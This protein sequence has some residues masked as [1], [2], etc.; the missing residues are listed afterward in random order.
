MTGSHTFPLRTLDKYLIFGNLP[1]LYQE[2]PSS[3]PDTLS[4]Y[5]ELYIENEIRQEHVVADMGAFARFLRLAALESGQCVN[6]TKLANAVGVAPNTLRNFYQALED[7]YVGIR[8]QSFARSRKR[9]L[10]SPRFLIL[11]FAISLRIFR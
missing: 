2:N 1:G 9:I 7:T 4:A 6:F 8:I 11:A 10:Q 3:W 5:A